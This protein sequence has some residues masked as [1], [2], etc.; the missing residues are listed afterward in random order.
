[1][2]PVANSLA[3]TKWVRKYHLVFTPKYRRKIIYYELRRNIQQIIK[4]LYKWKSV[5][6]IKGHMI[7]LHL[8]LGKRRG[9]WSFL[10]PYAWKFGIR[11]CLSTNLSAKENY[12]RFCVPKNIL[13]TAKNLG[14]TEVSMDVI[15][16]ASW[17]CRWPD[18]NRYDV[19]IEG[20]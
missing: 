5:E 18:L 13:W 20:F 15:F 2:F 17:W 8:I 9:V 3:H 1:M 10:V 6:I 12:L 11:F 19:A 7:L 14:K 4:D 16:I